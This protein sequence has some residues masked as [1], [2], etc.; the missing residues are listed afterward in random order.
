MHKKK[1][2][3]TRNNFL[4]IIITIILA[5]VA[6]FTCFSNRNLKEDTNKVV[7]KEINYQ[8]Y[9]ND[10]VI[11]K[12]ESYI[13]KLS[14]NE[15]IKA[16]TISSNVELKLNGIK[17]E[18]F[19]IDNLD[20]NYYIKYN[21]VEKIDTLSNSNERFK[22]Y[23]PF[24]K[25]IVTREKTRF[26][27]ENNNLIYSFNNSFNMPIII[28]DKDRYGVNYEDSL[29]YVKNTDVNEVIDSNNSTDKNIS[30]ISVLNYHYIY[31]DDDTSCN[32]SICMSESQFR[33]HLDYIKNND[34]LTVT[35]KELE[36]YIDGMI[37]LPK[38]VS[39]TIDDG[40]YLDNIKRILEEYKLN[41]TMFLVSG[42]FDISNYKSDY[43]ELHSH[44]HDM[45]DVGDCP[46]GQ[47][48][49]I[50]CFS[51]EDI[52]NDLKASREKLNGT[53]YFAYPFYEYNEYSIEMLKKAGFTMAFGGEYE[54]GYKY[55]KPGIDKFKLPRWVM[56]NYT[57]LNDLNTYLNLK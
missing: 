6:L 40:R 23:I 41:G 43:L 10:Y 19:L 20:D 25:N 16:G 49:A 31:K 56:V 3:I 5:L 9:Y 12:E 47:G 18:Y 32:E 14:S 37:Q 30:G 35:M 29:L 21:K 51:E 34:F 33:E 27:D 7:A 50:Q 8:S 36:M 22:R 11:T 46:T 38:S 28:M 39:I 45:H 53:T 17:D 57:T 26:Y 15:M 24:N 54:N 48:G 42:W 44:T 1:K 4:L 55:V 13:Y 2:K 52:Q